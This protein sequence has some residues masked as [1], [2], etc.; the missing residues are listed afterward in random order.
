MPRARMLDR[1]RYH[2]K[3]DPRL[4]SID[5]GR[6]GFERAAWPRARRVG[7]PRLKKPTTGI[8]YEDTPL[9]EMD[10]L[11]KQSTVADRRRRNP[12]HF[13]HSIAGRWNQ[14]NHIGG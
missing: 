7:N 9:A 6:R 13:R 5:K 8:A 3:R 10:I 2:C 4:S 14:R 1:L 11:G 12:K